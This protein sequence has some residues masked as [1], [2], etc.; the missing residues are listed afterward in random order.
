MI[1]FKKFDKKKIHIISSEMCNHLI[2]KKHPVSHRMT[3]GVVLITIGVI[4]T[5]IALLFEGV[6]VHA[7]ADGLGYLIHG[8][9]SVP[10]IQ[11]IIDE[12]TG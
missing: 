10:I 7:I 11:Y 12:A 8:I 1:N 9:G 5:K 2:G 6:Y 3:V 4:I